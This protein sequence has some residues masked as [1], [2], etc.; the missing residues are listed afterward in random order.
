[1]WRWSSGKAGAFSQRVLSCPLLRGS[2][3]VPS[4]Y[5]ACNRREDT[6]LK[7][8]SPDPPRTLIQLTGE[9]PGLRPGSISIVSMPSSK[10]TGWEGRFTPAAPAARSLIVDLTERQVVEL[11]HTFPSLGCLTI[12]PAWDGSGLIESCPALCIMS[13]VLFSTGFRSSSTPKPARP[14]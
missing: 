12:L 7:L 13:Q 5:A 6:R 2:A 1:M 4:G 11:I 10:F 8:N 9:S 14:S 3:V